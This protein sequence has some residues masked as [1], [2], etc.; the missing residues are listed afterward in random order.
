MNRKLFALA[1]ALAL[2]TMLSGCGIFG[3]GEGKKPKTPVLGQRISVLT[4][5]S[6]VEVDPTLEV[7]PVTPPEAVV[8]PEWSQPGG[9]ASKSMGHLAL[10]EQLGVA[11][12]R[13]IAGSD[14][15]KRLGAGPVVGGGKVYVMDVNATIHAFDLKSGAPAWTATLSDKD[16]NRDSLF[17]DGISYADGKI[18]ATNGVGDAGAF[19]AG[20]GSQLWKVR[21]GGPLRGAPTI[22]NDGVYVM[23]QD[24]QL[25][26]LKEANGEQIWNAS[27]SLENAAVFGAAA[28]AIGQGTVVAGFSSGELSAYRYE[29]GRSVWQDTLSRTS[30]TTSVA[31]LVDIDASPVIDQGRVFAVGQGGRMVS[32]DILTG[33]RLWELNLAG[34]ETPW[35]AGEWLFIVTDDAKI[36]CIA[37]NSGRI[38]WQTQLARYKDVKKKNKPIGWSGPVLAGGRLIVTNTQGQVVNI[39]VADGRIGTIT[40]L[41]DTIYQAPVVADNTLLV[42]TDKGKLV[43]YR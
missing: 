9:N 4:A 3:G 10:G 12:D 21:P 16:G 28:P 24:N 30:I 33:Q 17:G 32:M 15:K 7:V 35:I 37:R 11:W 23:S 5:E 42:L 18:F 31:S 19:D 43:A 34:I 1:G 27:G 38:R 29:N 39:A 22:G 13:K 40:K 6:G 36:L 2:S 41:G 25:Y 14:S 26:A 20:T 8:N